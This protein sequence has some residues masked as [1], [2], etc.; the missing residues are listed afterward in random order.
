M[1]IFFMSEKTRSLFFVCVLPLVVIAYI[2][3]IAIPGFQTSQQTPIEIT[4]SDLDTFVA[5]ASHNNFSQRYILDG[6]DM[7]DTGWIWEIETNGSK[8]IGFYYGIL[9]LDTKNIFISL[10]NPIDTNIFRYEVQLS[11]W[12]EDET[13]N[14]VIDDISQY[15]E[16]ASV[17][18]PVIPIRAVEYKSE[19]YSIWGD[20]GIVAL[21]LGFAL[22]YLYR[23]IQLSS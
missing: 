9:R 10:R 23:F 18:L 4:E 2:V 8:N 1:H 12:G 20:L 13:I 16:F 17:F 21:G 7:L 15:P 22:Y 3:I 6:T 14:K 11:Q 19:S 5:N